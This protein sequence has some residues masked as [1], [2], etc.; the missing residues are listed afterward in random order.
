[1]SGLKYFLQRFNAN[2]K[3][4]LFTVQKALPFVRGHSKPVTKG[5]ACSL[6]TGKK[7]SGQRLQVG[8]FFF[9]TGGHLFAR[10]AVDPLISN[11]ALPMLE[12]EVLIRPLVAGFDSTLMPDGASTILNAAIAAVEIGA[13]VT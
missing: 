8:T 9:K 11:A 6:E 10:C 12:Q 7:R 2:V 1:V 5:P 3:G 13:G 4:L